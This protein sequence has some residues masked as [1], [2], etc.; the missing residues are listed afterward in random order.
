MHVS[1]ISVCG[2]YFWHPD[3]T[4]FNVGQIDSD[5]LEN[6]AERSKINREVANEILREISTIN[7]ETS[8]E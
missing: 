3:A 4:Y 8:K 7:A 5:Q 6:Y 2:F 1:C